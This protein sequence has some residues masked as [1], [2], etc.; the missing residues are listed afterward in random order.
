MASRS[1]R[2]RGGSAARR[3]RR[4]GA[5]G[6]A[7]RLGALVVRLLVGEHLVDRV[8]HVARRQIHLVAVL[9]VLAPVLG[10]DAADED[11]SG[12]YA[13]A[14]A[15]PQLAHRI[16]DAHRAEHAARRVVRVEEGRQAERHFEHGALVVDR[17]ARDRP[18]VP[19]WERPR[20]AGGGRQGGARSAGQP[21]A[22]APL[23]LGKAARPSRRASS[24]EAAGA[25]TAAGPASNGRGCGLSCGRGG[26]GLPTAAFCLR[27][28]RALPSRRQRA[29]GDERHDL[30]DGRLQL[31]EDIGAAEPQPRDP[32][33]EHRRLA[34]LGRVLQRGGGDVPPHRLCRV[35]LQRDEQ[36]LRALL[37][38]VALH[39]LHPLALRHAVPVACAGG[40]AGAGARQEGMSSARRRLSA[41]GMAAGAA[42]E[43][44]A[45]AAAAAGT[46]ATSGGRAR[47]RHA[48]CGVT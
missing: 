31:V 18:L 10:A 16:A 43:P 6:G 14:R 27:A 3:A 15:Q 48:R 45:Q 11:M 24:R 32:H 34:E 13:D 19:A 8:A 4:G 36:V 12:R 28:R 5:Q 33:E 22:L 25:A 46:A 9:R 42:A 41:A 30:K 23:E 38:E 17:D 2:A 20:A 26:H 39:A 1:G 29:L 37:E 47:R 44:A 7:H 35:P 21:A 40:A